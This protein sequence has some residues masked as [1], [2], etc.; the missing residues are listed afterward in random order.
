LRDFYNNPG[1]LFHFFGVP[2]M[3]PQVV[4]VFVTLFSFSRLPNGS[5]EP[6]TTEGLSWAPPVSEGVTLTYQHGMQK[7]MGLAE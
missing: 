7:V 2:K 5:P 1:A 6:E 3:Y 4:F